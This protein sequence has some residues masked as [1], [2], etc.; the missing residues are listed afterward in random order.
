MQTNVTER[1]V[2]AGILDDSVPGVSWPAIFAGATGAAALSYVLVILGFGL[3]LSSVS[4]WMNT[5]TSAKALGIATIVWLAFTQIAASGM[6]GYLA[7]RLRSKW[8]GMHDDEVYFRD[9]AHGFLSWAVASLVVVAFLASSV[10]TVINGG[11]S[12][13]S[14]AVEAVG[15]GA[16][17]MA[18]KA[19]DGKDDGSSYF[20]D[21][22]FRSNAAN[23][24]DSASAEPEGVNESAM[25]VRTP[26]N[27]ASRRVEA[28]RIFANG[29]ASGSLSQGD[30][31]YLGQ[32]IADSTHLTQQE[33]EQRVD[34]AFADMK[35]SIETAKATALK[36][37]D[38]ARKLSAHASLWLFVSLMLGAF[39][40]SVA[41]IF[42]GRRRDKLVWT[43]TRNYR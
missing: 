2:D 20:V 23:N 37:T 22:L 16:S 32:V 43:S 42:G 12:V 7:G 3:G 11:A 14:A 41:A 29:L 5:G 18:S 36:A 35:Q 10:A 40:A 39:C 15:S 9:T 6:G 4:P 26:R 8:A 33:A 38:D 34:T 28:A 19:T 30:K 31:T 25:S 1:I 17:V 24:A 13:A 27:T 21:T